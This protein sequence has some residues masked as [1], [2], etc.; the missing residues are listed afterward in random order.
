MKNFEE[1]QRNISYKF[2]SASLLMQAM[3]HRSYSFEKKAKH[4]DNQRLEFFGDAVLELIASEY[5]FEAYPECTE[6]DLTKMRSAITRGEAL[7][8]LAQK[9]DLDSYM[10]VGKGESRLKGKNQ[11]KRVIDAF[12]ALLGALYL[13]GG[14]EVAR[15]FYFT[16]ARQC[17]SDPYELMLQQNPKGSLQELTQERFSKR[18]VY[19][20]KDIKG[21]D[22]EP[23]FDVEIH[24]SGEVIAR[25]QG[26]NRKS[27]EELAARAAI[28]FLMDKSK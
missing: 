11:E 4:V 17:W 23:L 6:G 12:E 16:V 25:G 9:L 2:K 13:D 27:A 26:R 28:S 14:M 15:D 3:T 21:D 5:L 1:L 8:D 24:M 19:V 20:T 18:P 10:Y 22:H 7:Y